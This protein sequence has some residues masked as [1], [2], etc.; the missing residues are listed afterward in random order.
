MRE[1]PDLAMDEIM[2]FEKAYWHDDASL[3]VKEI[4]FYDKIDAYYEKIGSAR[5]F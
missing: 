2:E 4:V 1:N 5:V 3:I